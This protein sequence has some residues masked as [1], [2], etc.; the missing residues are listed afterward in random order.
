MLRGVLKEN[1]TFSTECSRQ[2]GREGAEG[3]ELGFGGGDGR[4]LLRSY[5]DPLFGI[6]RALHWEWRPW[7]ACRHR[8]VLAI[9]PGNCYTTFLRVAATIW[10]TS[11]TTW[12]PDQSKAATGAAG[13]GQG[14]ERENRLIDLESGRQLV[15]R[16][17][18]GPASPAI[19][20]G[21]STL[22]GA[23]GRRAVHRR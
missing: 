18:K 13:H 8:A 19:A 10:F 21:A 3:E 14:S 17:A 20:N 11:A 9:F 5:R 22:G 15:A 4:G 2:I 7:S 23:P 16:L 1:F 12:P 6:G